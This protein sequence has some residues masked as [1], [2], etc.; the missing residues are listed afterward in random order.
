MVIKSYILC[1]KQLHD[2]FFPP[3]KSMSDHVPERDI[4]FMLFA[5]PMLRLFVNPTLWQYVVFYV[6]ELA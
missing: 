6:V 3:M 5:G 4:S 1:W 2:L